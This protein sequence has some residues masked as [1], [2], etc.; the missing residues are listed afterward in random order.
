M[1]VLQGA[2]GETLPWSAIL[3]QTELASACEILHTQEENPTA[4]NNTIVG[5]GPPVSAILCAN[6]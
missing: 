4:S 1:M 5:K 6:R 3:R 2:D